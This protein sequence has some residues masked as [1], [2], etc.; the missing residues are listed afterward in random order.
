MT[1]HII[2]LVNDAGN[3]NI[4]AMLESLLNTYG[5]PV[6]LLGTFLEGETILVLGGVAAHLG[7]LSPGWV[8][9]C[10]FAGTLFGDQLYF[11]LG[12]RHGSKFL[13]RRPAWQARSQHVH[14]ILERYP[15]LL[16]LGFRFLYGL[17]TVTPF[18]LGTSRVPYL[19]FTVLN[20]IGAGIW[21][22]A[23]GLAGFY[24]G[25]SVEIVLGEIKQYELQVMAF[26]L[27]T[28]LLTWIV[29]LMRRRKQDR[30]RVRK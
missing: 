9:V 14:R 15:I 3:S 4:T 29:F 7:Y 6:L 21:A 8:I 25:H 19:L 10:G 13:A 26:V 12:R 22:I 18:A 16:I 1:E 20:V 23:I 5:Y 17:R 24:F 27:V 28:G 2:L 11:Y 30:L